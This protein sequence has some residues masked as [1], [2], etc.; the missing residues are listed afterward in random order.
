MGAR[1]WCDQ[2]SSPAVVPGHADE[3][4]VPKVRVRAELVAEQH[5]QLVGDT[6]G[7][8]VLAV[9]VELHEDGR[10]GRHLPSKGVEGRGRSEWKGVEG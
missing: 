9:V 3:H 6:R 7:G 10:L 2:G 8:A 1:R 4:V 5:A